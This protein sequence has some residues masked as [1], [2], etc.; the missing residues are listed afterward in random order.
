M[1]DLHIALL[2][3]AKGPGIQ[4][5]LAKRLELLRASR[6]SGAPSWSWVSHPGYIEHS[7]F[8]CLRGFG[9][10]SHVRPEY[11][12]IDGWTA[13]KGAGLNRFGEVTGGTVRIRCKVRPMPADFILKGDSKQRLLICRASDPTAVVAYCCLDWMEC[14]ADFPGRLGLLLLSSGCNMWEDD[15]VDDEQD[16]GNGGQDEDIADAQEQDT[17]SEDE[18]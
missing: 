3:V 1:E 6:V 8:A 10:D 14:P 16:K 12:S 11:T 13:L 5:S 7:L 18:E 15:E 17:K 4:Q 9:T 2:W